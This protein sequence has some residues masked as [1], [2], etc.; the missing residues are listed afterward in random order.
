MWDDLE[1][2]CRILVVLYCSVILVIAFIGIVADRLIT[3]W[4]KRMRQRRGER[5]A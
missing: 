1:E 2:C 5:G 4:V 3:A